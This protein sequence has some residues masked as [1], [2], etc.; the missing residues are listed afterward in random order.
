MTVVKARAVLAEH[1]L[2]PDADAE[3][4]MAVLE[5]YGWQLSIEQVLGRGRGKQPRWSGNATRAAPPDSPAFR[6]AEHIRTQGENAREVVMR[7]LAKVVEKEP[8]P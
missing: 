4:L 6:H 8:T 7:I 5:G 3:E 1:G 2:N